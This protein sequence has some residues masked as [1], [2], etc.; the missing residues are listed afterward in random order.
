MESKT[1]VKPKQG[2]T[3]PPMKRAGRI[4]QVKPMLPAWVIGA[5]DGPKNRELSLKEGYGS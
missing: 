5:Y 4:A 2:R 1:K 3:N